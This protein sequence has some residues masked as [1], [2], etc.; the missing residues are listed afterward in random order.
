[1]SKE[2]ILRDVVGGLVHEDVLSD[3][4]QTN[5]V[6]TFKT[7]AYEVGHENWLARNLEHWTKQ[8]EQASGISTRQFL[9]HRAKN[10]LTEGSIEIGMIIRGAIR[11]VS[12]VGDNRFFGNLMSTVRKTLA[13]IILA[14]YPPEFDYKNPLFDAAHVFRYSIIPGYWEEGMRKLKELVG[15]HANLKRLL[16]RCGLDL[17]AVEYGHN[18]LIVTLQWERHS[19]ET[20]RDALETAIRAYVSGIGFDSDCIS[21]EID[22]Q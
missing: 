6:V 2:L 16:H 3:E 1:M 22:P 4:G 10:K 8:T 13:E 11:I 5:F 17:R 7:R 18:H 20:E 19:T 21:L 14:S 12:G 15:N 9:I